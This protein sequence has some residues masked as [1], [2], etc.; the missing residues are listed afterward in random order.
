[1]WSDPNLT[2][3]IAVMAHWIEAKEV[4]TSSSVQ[5]ILELQANLIAFHCVPGHYTGTHL[6]HTFKFATDQLGIIHKVHV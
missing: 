5:H 2:P 1:M 3:F 6:A 4:Q